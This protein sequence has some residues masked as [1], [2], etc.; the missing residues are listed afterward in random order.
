V[1]GEATEHAWAKE[2]EAESKRL[3][4]L[5]GKAARL[6]QDVLDRDLYDRTQAQ[7]DQIRQLLG[8]INGK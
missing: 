3:R 2:L 7:P 8:E 1:S 6:L 4:E 5:L